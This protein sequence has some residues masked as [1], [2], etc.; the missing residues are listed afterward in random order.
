MRFATALRRALVVLACYALVLQAGLAAF[1]TASVLAQ[2]VALGDAPIICHGFDVGRDGEGSAPADKAP[3]AHC[4][5]AAASGALVPEPPA[6]GTTLR[7][8]SVAANSAAD[9]AAPALFDPRAGEARAPPQV[10]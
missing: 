7:V 9:R 5:L 3:C 4:A 8:T 6:I 10:S 1:A 2:T